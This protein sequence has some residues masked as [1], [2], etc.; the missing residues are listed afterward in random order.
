[1]KVDLGGMAKGFIVDKGIE[2]LGETGIESAF[3]NAGGNIRVLGPKYEDRPWHIGIR[4]PQQKGEIFSKHIIAL[5]EGSVATSGDY[6][7]YFTV[8]GRR[9]SHLIDPRT[10]YQ[11][12]GMQSVTIYAPDALSADILSTAIFIMGQ[13]K[14]Q[15][16]INKMPSIEGFMVEDEK[17]L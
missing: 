16:L 11:A 17:D 12:R 2:T 3:I 14:G 10:G 7:R 8:A 13:D 5:K 6:E 9:Y 1:M 4:K 15:K